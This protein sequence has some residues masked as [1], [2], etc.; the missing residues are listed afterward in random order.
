[1]R[2]KLAQTLLCLLHGSL[3]ANILRN[4]MHCLARECEQFN[5]LR[6]T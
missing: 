1:M 5:V 2:R 6:I 4:V 3:T